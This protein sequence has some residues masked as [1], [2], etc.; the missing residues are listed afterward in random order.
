MRYD[1]GLSIG[2][3]Y[4]APAEHLRT[5]V[6]LLPTDQ[7]GRQV[8]TVRLLSVDPAPTERRETQDFFGNVVTM[9]AFHR[10]VAQ[11]DLTLR[12]RVER[13]ARVAS[14]DLSPDL[15]GLR[16]EIAA[17]PGLDPGAPHHY[18]G[19][20][21]RVRPDPEISAFA[22][23]VVKPGMTAMQ[24]VT[25]LGQALHATMRF[26]PSTTDVHTPASVAFA[27]RSGVCQDFSHIMIAGLR[28][29]GIPAGYVSGFLRTTPPPGQKRLE[30]ADAMHAWVR[31]WCGSEAGWIEHDPTNAC[32]V[33]QDHIVVAY[34]RD[35][36][37]VS[38]VRGAL[39]TTGDQASHQRVDVVAL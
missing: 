3:R 14:L 21:A 33:G 6:R 5:L 31:A 22:A 8:V 7:P 39:R 28:S 16:A 11:F 10:P 25:A 32:A 1:I 9:L 15:A 34:G 35:Y 13:V 23:A 37:D 26:D 24:I 2:Y 27:A 29:L 17:R 20:S 12:A 30:G 19:P 18:L 36:A 4:G 38:P